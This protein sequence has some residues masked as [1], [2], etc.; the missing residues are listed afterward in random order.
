[1]AGLLRDPVNPLDTFELARHVFSTSDP[2]SDQLN[3]FQHRGEDPLTKGLGRLKREDAKAY[4]DYFARKSG[5]SLFAAGVVQRIPRLVGI[6][7]GGVNETKR[8]SYTF[9]APGPQPEM[10]MS[11]GETD[12]LNQL[13]LNP[14]SWLKAHPR[15]PIGARDA[16]RPLAKS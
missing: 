15:S 1:M 7:I 11:A 3:A 12:A 6:D 13:Y 5:L 2:L 16:L 10:I 14:P 4:D 8:V 9:P